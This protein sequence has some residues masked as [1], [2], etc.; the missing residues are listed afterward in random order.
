MWTAVCPTCGDAWG[1]RTVARSTAERRGQ[2]GLA[3]AIEVKVN[4]R[5]LFPSP[6]KGRNRE[7]LVKELGFSHGCDIRE[8][9][10]HGA[11]HVLPLGNKET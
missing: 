6:H 4:L 2:Q 9:S 11:I 3:E 8:I 10:K 1:G 7:E 5:D